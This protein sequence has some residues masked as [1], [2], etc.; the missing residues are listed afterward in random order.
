MKIARPAAALAPKPEPEW[1]P[2]GPAAGA[3]RSPISKD[4]FRSRARAPLAVAPGKQF[5]R[6][7]LSAEDRAASNANA[8]LRWPFRPAST[9]E[10]AC[11]WP[12]KVS[13]AHMAVQQA[14][15]TFFST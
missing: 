8:P 5:V 14:I 1:L 6:L 4:S 2:A 3:A 9:R 10:R 13:L 7:A 15:C 11:A 12:V